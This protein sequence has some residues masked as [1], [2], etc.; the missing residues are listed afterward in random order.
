MDRYM[1][2]K[3]GGLLYTPAID[4]KIAYRIKSN[5][6]ENLTSLAIC[7]EDSITDDVLDDA[8]QN[9]QNI[10]AE[11][12]SVENIPMI[13]IRVRSPEHLRHV[14]ELIGG[15]ADVLT[16][17]ILPKFSLDN[18]EKYLEITKQINDSYSKP[19]YIM[20][21]IESPMFTAYDGEKKL[22]QLKC[23]LDDMRDYI[24]N[25]RVGGND[26]LNLYG[27]RRN[28]RQN[29]Y[30]VGVVRDIFVKILN[31]F[32]GEY[33]VSGAVWEYYDNGT[34]DE[35]KT[36]LKQELELD[37]L[38]GFIGK[39]AIHPSQLPIILD[40]LKPYRQDYDDAKSVLSWHDAA[41]VK[42][43]TDGSRMNEV[44]T[45]GKWAERILILG[46]IYGV[47]EKF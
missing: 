28:I 20:P 43:S 44:K 11:L 34:G 24:L 10:M 26:F 18:S 33:V 16:G 45:H 30:Q 1:P 46:E 17:F 37:R 27:I 41:G 36:G 8:E 25:I 13:F 7:L 4:K 19:L 5:A 47:K 35:W 39:T 6:I 2:Y 29:I 21:T 42:G 9:L 3:V 31:V 32:A 22:E 40:S 15:Y 14:Y 38:N 23:Q 12:M